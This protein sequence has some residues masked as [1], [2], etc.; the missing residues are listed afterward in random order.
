MTKEQ[1]LKI[2]IPVLVIILAIVYGDLLKSKKPKQMSGR[3]EE[4]AV[5]GSVNSLKQIELLLDKKQEFSKSS[6]LEWKRNPFTLEESELDDCRYVLHG[7]V[8]DQ[9]GS[10]AIIN[11]SIAG[12]GDVVSG[13]TIISINKDKVT[14]FD[15]Q[16]NIEIH[17]NKQKL[18]NK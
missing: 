16:E 1:K 10:K 13:L 14:A 7:I 8:W 17:I 2:I 15:G 18:K 6:Y 5:E 9:E 3:I 4:E 11:E 12:V